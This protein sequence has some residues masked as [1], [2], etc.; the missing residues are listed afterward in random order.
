MLEELEIEKDNELIL[1]LISRREVRRR[2]HILFSLATG[3]G[4]S[5]LTVFNNYG[6]QGLYQESVNQ[7]KHRKNIS[8]SDNVLDYMESEELIA[9]LFRIL[10][11][12][13]ILKRKIPSNWN[14]ACQTHF[15]VGKKIRELMIE[16]GGELP[17]NMSTPTLSIDAL[18]KEFML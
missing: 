5:N 18:E 11:T 12:T 4:V 10:Q 7:I 3:Y 8:Y 15:Y 6:Y 17:E 1:R 2:N 14:Y 13:N 16:L 9:N